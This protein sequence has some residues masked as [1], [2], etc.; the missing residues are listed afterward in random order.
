MECVLSIYDGL[1]QLRSWELQMVSASTLELTAVCEERSFGF[2]VGGAMLVK[3]SGVRNF[4]EM[5]IHSQQYPGIP[6]SHHYNIQHINS[7]KKEF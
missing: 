1:T 5:C 6:L 7:L 4:L 2:Q 3:G